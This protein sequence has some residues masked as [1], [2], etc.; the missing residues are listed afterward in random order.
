M[1]VFPIRDIGILHKPNPRKLDLQSITCNGSV[2]VHLNKKLFVR[3]DDDTD[4]EARES[5]V[6]AEQDKLLEIFYF[7][8]D[9]LL[10]LH[11]YSRF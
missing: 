1:L 9:I 8:C 5:R 6:L 10:R 11:K 3:K 4:E 7:G 2:D